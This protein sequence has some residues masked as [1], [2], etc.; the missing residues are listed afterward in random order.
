MASLQDSTV[1][2]LQAQSA[3]SEHSFRIR[4]SQGNPNISA[5]ALPVFR[6]HSIEDLSLGA[7]CRY[8]ASKRAQRAASPS[9]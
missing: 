8:L 9:E 4:I 1:Q 5:T 2:G 3:R 7:R 6:L